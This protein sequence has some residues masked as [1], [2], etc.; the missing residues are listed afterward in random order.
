MLLLYGVTECLSDSCICGLI[1]PVK[2]NMLYREERYV[3]KT[4]NSFVTSTSLIWGYTHR[5]YTDAEVSDAQGF[6][7]TERRI[8]Y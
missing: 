1:I 8:Y 2:E 5:V 4:G 3:A 7:E 6:P